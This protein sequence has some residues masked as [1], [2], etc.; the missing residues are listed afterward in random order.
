VILSLA[1]LLLIQIGM[2]MH[3]RAG[4][5]LLAPIHLPVLTE[6]GEHQLHFGIMMLLAADVGFLTPPEDDNL[7]V[8][9]AIS[10]LALER[11]A[12]CPLPF[13]IVLLVLLFVLTFIEPVFMFLP[14]LL[15]GI[16]K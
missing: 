12:K 7:N 5:I 4:T 1:G 13:T 15:S 6:L 14:E 8:A 16:T 3:T 2:H 10:G 9:S 11:V